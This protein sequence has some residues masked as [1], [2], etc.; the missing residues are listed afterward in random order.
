MLKTLEKNWA[1]IRVQHYYKLFVAWVTDLRDKYWQD[2]F[3]RTEFNVVALQITFAFVLSI[4]VVSS[5]NYFYKDI[6]ETIVRTLTDNIRNNTTFSPTSVINSMQVIQAKNFFWFL[7]VTVSITII[8]SYI[9]AKMTLSPARTALNS[10]KRF[11][12]DIAHELRTPLSVIKTKSEVA[13]LEESL[14]VKTRKMFQDTV[15]E[16]DR[17]SGIINNLL[18]FGN[19]VHPGQI[20]FKSV[21]LGDVINTAIEKLDDL[22]KKK[23]V[24]IKIQKTDPSKVWGN[25]TALEQI[26]I[27]IVKNAIN[28]NNLGGVVSITVTPDYRG[29]V[30]LKVADTGIGIP[31]KDI[32]HIFEP[33]FRAEKSRSRQFGSSGLG[34]TIVSELVKLHSGKISVVSR[35]KTGTIVTVVLPYTKTE[36]EKTKNEAEVPHEVSVDFTKRR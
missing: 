21:D 25:T 36:P 26:V 15:E 9:I 5:F 19:L 14:S 7:G 11:I 30:V 1:W 33:F 27:N 16:L 12:S 17:V 34:L 6:L 3:F 35:P 23:E 31:E 20:Q 2:I 13:L 24:K 29:N 10:Q 8:F 22:I 32:P 18:T 4:L 28:Y